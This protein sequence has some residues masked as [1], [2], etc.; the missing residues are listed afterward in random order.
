MEKSGWVFVTRG[1]VRGVHGEVVIFLMMIDEL[2]CDLILLHSILISND[3]CPP[4]TV[5]PS[6]LATNARHKRQDADDK[7]VPEMRVVTG[8]CDASW[9]WH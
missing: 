2:C 4:L 5:S 1:V 6:L 9:V 8:Q 3:I 7:K